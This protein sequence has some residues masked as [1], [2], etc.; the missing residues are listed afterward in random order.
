MMNKSEKNRFLDEVVRQFLLMF[1]GWTLASSDK[2]HLSRYCERRIDGS[3]DFVLIADFS[4]A[5]G[6]DRL[7]ARVGWCSSISKYVS[8]IGSR[9]SPALRRQEGLLSRIRAV[10]MA[11]EFE[12]DCFSANLT[13]LKKFGISGV[14]I[15]P[16][17]PD[18]ARTAIFSDFEEF[19]MPYFSLFLEFKSKKSNDS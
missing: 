8:Q 19:G 13:S 14:E 15:T 17:Q 11:R 1:E 4:I 3:M 2:K 6:H 12:Y 10:G 18:A 7:N 9:N 16:D 5:D